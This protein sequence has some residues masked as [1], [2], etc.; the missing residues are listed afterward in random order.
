MTTFGLTKH[1]QDVKEKMRVFD[2]S[3]CQVKL[4]LKLYNIDIIIIII[5]TT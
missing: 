3:H 4:L 5:I 2:L 1:K